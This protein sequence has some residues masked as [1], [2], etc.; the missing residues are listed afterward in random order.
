MCVTS[1]LNDDLHRDLKVDLVIDIIKKYAEAHE[2]RL[3]HHVNIEAIQ[4]LDN[5]DLDYARKEGGGPRAGAI[6]LLTPQPPQQAILLASGIKGRSPATVSAGLRSA[7]KGSSPPDQNQ[8]R[9]YG[10]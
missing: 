3:H 1:L 9:G 7:S 4:L 2:R 5:S 6:L 10:A 8:A